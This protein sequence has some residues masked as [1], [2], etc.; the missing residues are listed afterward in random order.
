MKSYQAS[1][2][3]D[4][5]KEEEKL[6][7]GQRQAQ[8]RQRWCVERADAFYRSHL[9][10]LVGALCFKD[11]RLLGEMKIRWNDVGNIAHGFAGDTPLFSIEFWM[12]EEGGPGW[13]N[14]TYRDAVRMTLHLPWKNNKGE[15]VSPGEAYG[16]LD[17]VVLADYLL[18]FVRI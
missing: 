15:S 12:K 4:R 2:E 16:H 17:E 14:G 9:R 11:E 3:A 13:H 5:L 18:N 6:R 8:E 10:E 7:E 1:L